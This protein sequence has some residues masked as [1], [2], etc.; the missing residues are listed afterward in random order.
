MTT[1]YID[2]KNI[3]L[4]VS[5]GALCL[6]EPGAKARSL[7]LAQLERV[8][9][10]GRANISTSTLGAVTAAGA[11]ILVL[12]GRRNEKIACLLGKPHN[13]VL[14]RLG[15]FDAYRDGEARLRWSK[16]LVAA[17]VGAQRNLLRK[18][19]ARRPDKRRALT[20]AG[21]QLDKA[22]ERLERVAGDAAADNT[23]ADDFPIATLLGIEGFAAAAYFKAF[24]E[25]LPPSLGFNSRRRRPPPD[26]VNACLSLAYTLLHFEA[27]S[28]CHEAGLEPMLGL[29]HEPAFGRESLAS[30]LIEPFRPHVDAWVWSMFR[31]RFLTG[32][33]F[34]KSGEAALLNKNG[35][36]KFYA[37]F[38]P[39]AVALRRLLRRQSHLAARLFCRRAAAEIPASRIF[40]DLQ[41]QLEKADEPASEQSRSGRGGQAGEEAESQ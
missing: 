21:G 41:N 12:S 19:L 39:L 23:V 36:G 24:A 31:E 13:D 20:R 30:D 16:S 28:A 29:Y 15:Q 35:R 32:D 34:S 27:V 5:G 25:L 1:L 37:K 17:K 40:D 2:R 3:E 26:P 9:I 7:P 22:I 33:N 18:A 38:N 8:V 4:E 10:R 11:G 6:R 14:R